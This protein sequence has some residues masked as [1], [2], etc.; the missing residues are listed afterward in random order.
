LV[1]LLRRSW[2]KLDGRDRSEVL[3]LTWACLR[4]RLGRE[5]V[6]AAVGQLEIH[7]LP[8]ARAC[9]YVLPASDFALGLKVGQAFSGGDMNIARKLGVT[10]AEVDKLCNAMVKALGKGPL[11]PEHLR[12]STGG[13]ARSLGEEG[14]KKGI[15][16]TL[17]L[18]L[19]KLQAEGEIRRVP[20]NGRLDQQRYRYTLWRPNPLT[21]FKLSADEAYTELARRFFGWIGPATL[22]EFRWFSALGVKASKDAVEPLKLEPVEQ[23]DDRLMLP[24]DSEKLKAFKIPKEPQFVL[25]SGLDGISLLRRDLKS[26]LATEDRK[27]RVPGEKAPIEAG[28]LMDLP[29]HAIFD[30]GRVV[31]LWEYDVATQTI[32]WMPFVRIDKVLKNAV[33]LMETYIRNE[34]GDARSFS[35]DSS[36]SRAP[37]IEALRAASASG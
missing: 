1:G 15:T 3:V 30:R 21:K 10:D 34:L 18:A 27:R 23:G 33:E 5:A 25:S 32:V 31:G 7:E 24:G 26:L 28:G 2:N 35:L 37:R 16:T 13:A 22:A 17:P 9:T 19:R 36:K 4:A 11:D 14:K 29:S 12:E 20:I 8:S 6:D